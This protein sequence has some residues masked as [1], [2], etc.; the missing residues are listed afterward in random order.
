MSVNNNNNSNNSSSGNSNS[1]SVSS[2][3]NRTE[4]SCEVS[5]TFCERNFLTP[6]GGAAVDVTAL[7]KARDSATIREAGTRALKLTFA[8]SSCSHL[9]DEPSTQCSLR[10]PNLLQTITEDENLQFLCQHQQKQL[11]QRRN[12]YADR[13]SAAD[14]SSPSFSAPPTSHRQSAEAQLHLD[15]NV[16]TVLLSYEAFYFWRL[17]SLAVII[18]PSSDRFTTLEFPAI[19][20]NPP[21]GDKPRPLACVFKPRHRNHFSPL[22]L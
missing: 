14:K 15:V 3:K 8:A 18:A 1:R 16:S 6:A 9:G 4:S 17:P 13:P 21:L 10:N 5:G 20:S 11:S 7:P 19:S 12:D 2:S 22:C